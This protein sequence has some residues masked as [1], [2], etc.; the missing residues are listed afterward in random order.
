MFQ[1]ILAMGSGVSGASKPTLLASSDSGITSGSFSY[2]ATPYDY[3]IVVAGVS[4][5]KG[6]SIMKTVTT[7]PTSLSFP[8]NYGHYYTGV[9]ATATGLTWEYNPD[10][11][12]L[13]AVYGVKGTVFDLSDII[14]NI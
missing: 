10:S 2:D 5:Q 4:G 14:S 9:N 6:I 1:D 7:K 3:I 8:Q 13:F 12:R 11:M